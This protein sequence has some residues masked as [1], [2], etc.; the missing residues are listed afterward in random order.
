MPRPKKP[1]ATPTTA[2]PPRDPVSIVT[3]AL[4]GFS[5]D[6]SS[7]VLDQARHEALHFVEDHAAGKSPDAL[8]K[9]YRVPPERITAG[10]MA[11]REVTYSNPVAAVMLGGILR[12]VDGLDAILARTVAV[13][14]SQP[15]PL[16]VA[17]ALIDAWTA[18]APGFVRVAL[19]AFNVLRDHI[20]GVLMKERQDM[21]SALRVQPPRSQAPFMGPDG[22][23]AVL[24]FVLPSPPSTG[25]LA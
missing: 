6:A 20:A 18:E 13:V 11:I 15:P 24:A 5:P 4:Y 7:D 23:P 12:R 2:S 10:I 25:G 9:I 17:T 14:Q 22:Q 8:A 19:S 16:K 3:A 1:T 21:Q